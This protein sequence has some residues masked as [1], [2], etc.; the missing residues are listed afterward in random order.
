ER[1]ARGAVILSTL[2]AT[3]VTEFVRRHAHKRSA[4]SAQ[5]IV[6]SLRAYLRYLRYQG[7]ITTD[8]AACVPKVAN[9]SHSALPRFLQPGQVQKVLDHCDRRSS[10]GLLFV[11]LIRPTLMLSFGPP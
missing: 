1:F 3:D 2:S 10:V 11:N 7:E 5:H 8:L 9:W 6:G 4:R